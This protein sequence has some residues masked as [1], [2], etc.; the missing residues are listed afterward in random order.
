MS[1]L[2]YKV[3]AFGA[4]TGI[5]L[6]C[7]IMMF[8]YNIEYKNMDTEYV[9]TQ[10]EI[11]E[12]AQELGMSFP[13]PSYQATPTPTPSQTAEPTPAIEVS[14]EVENEEEET[15]EDFSE[16][17]E[18]QQED[19]F[20]EQESEEIV[21]NKVDFVAGENDSVTIYVYEGEPATVIAAKLENAGV[22][23]S[24][25]DFIFFLGEKNS[26]HILRQGEFTIEIGTPYEDIHAI[27]IRR[28]E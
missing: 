9:L 8:V 26:Y 6:V 12:M 23:E 1:K 28:M 16:E 17:D 10:D 5:V 25:A 19:E 22:I 3:F 2:N 15:E 14:Q 7:M 13:T 24:A 27:L 11:I 20:I 18:V 4:G 21:Q